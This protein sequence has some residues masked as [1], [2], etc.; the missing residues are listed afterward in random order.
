MSDPGI[1]R[2]VVFKNRLENLG[3]SLRVGKPQQIR[4]RKQLV[5]RSRDRRTAKMRV[6]GVRRDLKESQ[7]YPDAFG[8]KVAKLLLGDPLD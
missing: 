2:V 3:D 1:F 8:Q 4:N 6:T 5:V 7:H